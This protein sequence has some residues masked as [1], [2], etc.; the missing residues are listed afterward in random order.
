MPKFLRTHPLSD[1]R[2]SRIKQVRVAIMSSA[3][4]RLLMTSPLSVVTVASSPTSQSCFLHFAGAAHGTRDVRAGR[5]RGTSRPDWGP[6]WG[7][8]RRWMAIMREHIR[9]CKPLRARSRCSEV[10]YNTTHPAT[11][12]PLSLRPSK[13][14]SLCLAL[15][16]LHLM[17]CPNLQY[18]GGSIGF[19]RVPT[20]ACCAGCA[21]KHRPEQ[22]MRE[23]VRRNGLLTGTAPSREGCSDAPP[24][25]AAGAR[26]PPRNV[27]DLT[28]TSLPWPHSSCRSPWR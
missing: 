19:T 22:V 8:C 5:V 11:A 13:F 25:A 6:L 12:M 23:D 16:S 7:P 21:R 17:L 14:L 15:S 27:P 24:K 26:W 10:G 4:H 3:V 9:P 18:R 20:V 2:V 28:Q 1:E